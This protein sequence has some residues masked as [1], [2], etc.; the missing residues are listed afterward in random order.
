MTGSFE[1]S[2]VRQTYLDPLVARLREHGTMEVGRLTLQL[3]QSFGFCW[4]VDRALA[5]VEKA[6]QEF[7]EQRLWLLS[8]LI[9]NPR[10]NADM[11]RMGIGFL[12][13]PLA[14]PGAFD[15]LGVGDV[16]IIPA[17]SAEVEDMLYLESRGVAIVDTTCP[18]VIKPH[19]RTLKFL[20]EGFTTVIHG[21]VGHDE[22]RATCSLVQHEGGH[23]VVVHDLGE[24]EILAGFLRGTVAAEEMRRQLHPQ[25]FSEGFDLGVHTLRLGLI[26]QT[27]MLAAESRAIGN[28]LRLAV[29]ERDG[30]EGLAD[31]FRD[32]DTICRATQNNQDAALKVA[33][34]NPDLFLVVG[35]YD[36]SNTRNLARV[37]DNANVPA[38][39]IEGPDAVAARLSYRD[40]ASGRIL[41]IEDWLPQQGPVRIAF[42]AGASTPDTIL[43]SVIERVVR[44]AGE[45]LPLSAV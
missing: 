21:T 2:D 16:V 26:N 11:R 5:M 4:G 23:F 25:A 28:L 44:L 40:R 13:G 38:F 42:S 14:E 12:K 31:S 43:G 29:L 36:S 3:P 20:R 37:G 24:A 22:T 9:H 15:Q 17:F 19:K 8:S 45:N 35:G 27:T 7:P 18:W 32:F 10:V 30:E 6:R 33:G 39:H 34:D 41:E 1:D